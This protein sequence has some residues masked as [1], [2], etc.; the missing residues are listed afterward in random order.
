MIND[1]KVKN[2]NVIYMDEAS[3]VFTPSKNYTVGKKCEK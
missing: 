3:I 1:A 2:Y